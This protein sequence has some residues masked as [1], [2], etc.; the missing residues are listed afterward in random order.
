MIASFLRRQ[1]AAAF[2]MALMF[3]PPSEAFAAPVVQACSLMDGLHVLQVG[4]TKREFVVERGPKAGAQPGP[5]V[6][7]WHGY[8]GYRPRNVSLIP[9]REWPEAIRIAPKGLPRTLPGYGSARRR[10]WQIRSGEYGDRDLAF[11]DALVRKLEASGCADPAQIYSTGF[12]NGGFFSNLL[13]CRR[14]D[15]LA[16]V[17]PVGGGGPFEDCLGEVPVLVFHGT[18]DTVVPFDFAKKTFE[19]WSKV[20]GCDAVTPPARG[21]LKAPGCRQALRFCGA[22]VAHTW[23]PSASRRI[24]QFMKGLRARKAT[25]PAEPAPARK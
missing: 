23:P 11:F 12:S 1:S 8:G 10:G 4:E 5:V 13:A 17:A 22:A 19:T 25:T 20:N 18:K 9:G 2:A 3:C 6:F 16:A 15:R 14:A 21:C 7:I 24:V